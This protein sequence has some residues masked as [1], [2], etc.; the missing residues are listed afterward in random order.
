VEAL[1][2]SKIGIFDLATRISHMSTSRGLRNLEAKP[3]LEAERTQ[4]TGCR[5]HPV[6]EDAQLL[7]DLD[8]LVEPPTPR[9][10]R[11]RR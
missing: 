10:I 11:D 7:E 4:R 5:K 9:L 1:G 8:G 2:N 6:E 3:A